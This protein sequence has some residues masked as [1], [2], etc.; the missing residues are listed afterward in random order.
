VHSSYV[1][2]RPRRTSAA[3]DSSGRSVA[4]LGSVPYRKG[5]SR[6]SKKA[7]TTSRNGG[8]RFAMTL[9]SSPGERSIESPNSLPNGQWAH[10]VV[11]LSGS[12]GTLYVN[13]IAVDTNTALLY[14]PFRR[15]N[16]DANHI[17]SS[18]YPADPYLNALIEDFRIY[19]G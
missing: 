5:S 8:V 11:T 16:T 10:V 13:G 19:W 3:G 14:A 17:G 12:T 6:G 1:T 9:N 4:K 15:G 2:S 18:Q 7:V